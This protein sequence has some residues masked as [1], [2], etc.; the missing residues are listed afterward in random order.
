VVFDW[1]GVWEVGVEEEEVGVG[2]G[3]VIVWRWFVV[4]VGR[5]FFLRLFF[6]F[7]GLFFVFCVCV[8]MGV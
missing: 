1:V 8:F 3:V 4:F 6:G 7:L 5:G 2:G